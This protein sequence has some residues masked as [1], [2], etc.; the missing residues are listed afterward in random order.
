MPNVATSWKPQCEQLME[1]LRVTPNLWTG[2]RCHSHR[3][4]ARHGS[5]YIC[6]FF[7]VAKFLNIITRWSDG[8]ETN[9]V[10]MWPICVCEGGGYSRTSFIDSYPIRPSPIVIGN[11]VFIWRRPHAP[12]TVHLTDG[13]QI[14]TLLPAFSRCLL[15]ILPIKPKW[16]SFVW[17]FIARIIR[18]IRENLTHFIT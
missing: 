11:V 3:R 5:N 8:N 2:N 10:G 4:C 14:V 18:R 1:A 13:R 6:H 9:T 15:L 17:M 16:W 12:R 7:R